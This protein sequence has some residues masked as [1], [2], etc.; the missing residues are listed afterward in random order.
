M[1]KCNEK[2]KNVILKDSNDNDIRDWY[3]DSKYIGDNA[4][5]EYSNN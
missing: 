1:K 4:N 2:L 3:Y 5:K